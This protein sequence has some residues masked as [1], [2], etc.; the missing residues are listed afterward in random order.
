MSRRRLTLLLDPTRCDGHG[1]CSE[2][3]P[4]GVVLDRWGYP[5]IADGYIPAALVAH[6]RL[7]VEECPRLALHLVERRP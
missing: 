4:E 1:V 2:L 5:V 7:A 3:F 6:A